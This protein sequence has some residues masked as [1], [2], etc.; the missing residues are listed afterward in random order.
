MGFGTELFSM[1]P[2]E[3]LKI[4]YKDGW[5]DFTQKGSHLQLKHDKKPGKVTFSMP[6]RDIPVKT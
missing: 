6:H 1:T 3:A 4:L 2:K 5:F